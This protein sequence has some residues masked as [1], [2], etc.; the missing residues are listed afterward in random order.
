MKL[1][2]KNPIP[3]ILSNWDWQM[4][5]ERKL[6]DHTQIRTY[7]IMK[8]L[9]GIHRIPSSKI[10]QLAKEHGMKEDSM[11]KLIYNNHKYF[12]L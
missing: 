10:K 6:L 7:L 1:Y 2:D 12:D 8:S 9:I 4:L 11:R 3:E 5:N